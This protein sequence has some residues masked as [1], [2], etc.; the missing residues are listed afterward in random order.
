MEFCHCMG[1]NRLGLLCIC[2]FPN[3]NEGFAATTHPFINIAARDKTQKGQKKKNNNLKTKEKTERTQKK[4]R[5]KERKKK[6]HR[7]A[8]GLEVAFL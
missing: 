3:S 5:K 1:R 6:K 7:E 4:E 8:K 2:R